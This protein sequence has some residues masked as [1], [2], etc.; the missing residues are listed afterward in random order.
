MPRKNDG[1]GAVLILQAVIDYPS[2]VDDSIGALVG[3]TYQRVQA[4]RYQ[5]G[6]L[7]AKKRTLRCRACR[8]TVRGDHICPMQ[9]EVDDLE[10][11]PVDLSKGLESIAQARNFKRKSR[12]SS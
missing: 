1:V 6:I 10:W 11:L 2:L 7:A 9:G 12:R 5:Y 3:V 8:R 4:V